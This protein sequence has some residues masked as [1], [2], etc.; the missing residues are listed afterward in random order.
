MK[1]NN[2]S[3]N[4]TLEKHN[5]CEKWHKIVNNGGTVSRSPKWRLKIASGDS[6]KP[7]ESLFTIINDKEMQQIISFFLKNKNKLSRL[8]VVVKKMFFSRPIN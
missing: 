7:K 3:S 8:K 6:P 2:S 4:K 1:E 5:E